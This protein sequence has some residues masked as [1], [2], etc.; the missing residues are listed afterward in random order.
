MLLF[1]ASAVMV[2]SKREVTLT[3]FSYFFGQN[4]QIIEKLKSFENGLFL[5]NQ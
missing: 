4:M 1:F 5:V 3:L 2:V